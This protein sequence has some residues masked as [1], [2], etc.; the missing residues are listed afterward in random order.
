MKKVFASD[1][2][3]T[4]YFY[5]AEDDRKLPAENVEKIREYQKAGHLFGLCTGRQVGGLTRIVV[6]RVEVIGLIFSKQ[7][8]Q[9]TIAGIAIRSRL[10]IVFQN[11]KSVFLLFVKLRLHLDT[12]VQTGQITLYVGTP[13]GNRRC[14]RQQQTEYS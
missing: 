7:T 5:K 9:N 3:G 4:L 10:Q 1:F 12:T 11:L 2:D 8:V 14:K 6:S 13:Y